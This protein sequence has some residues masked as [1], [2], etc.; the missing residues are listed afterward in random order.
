MIIVYTWSVLGLYPSVHCSFH[1][2]SQAASPELTTAPIDDCCRSTR[3]LFYLIC[4]NR[5]R[6]AL[7]QGNGYCCPNHLRFVVMR[8]CLR[9]SFTVNCCA[10][11]IYRE[12]TWHFCLFSFA[13]CR[14]GAPRLVAVR[15]GASSRYASVRSSAFS[16]ARLRGI[17]GHMIMDVYT[18]QIDGQRERETRV[19]AGASYKSRTVRTGVRSGG[20]G[21]CTPHRANTG[22]EPHGGELETKGQRG[23]AR[24]QASA[25]PRSTV[26]A[27]A[28][29]GS[30]P[31]SAGRRG[32]REGGRVG[33]WRARRR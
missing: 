7:A 15:L 12:S 16:F 23:R 19:G 1:S 10:L 5:T 33:V 20:S 25:R 32:R 13:G 26:V 14:A 2:Q 27:L 18:A 28:V 24:A 8:C 22:I 31:P 29:K 11:R 21:R 17:F 6:R 4:H 9:T 3:Q 30:A